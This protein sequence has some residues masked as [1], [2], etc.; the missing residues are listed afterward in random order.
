M[1]DG[2]AYEPAYG[3][4]VIVI[5]VDGPDERATKAD[6]VGLG[7]LLGE[8]VAIVVRYLLV[9]VPDD[10]LNRGVFVV[11]GCKARDLI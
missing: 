4:V 7:E 8:G 11:Y 1:R 9:A 3:G 6:A 5:G 2:G 10:V